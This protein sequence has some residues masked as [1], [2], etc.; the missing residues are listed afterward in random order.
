MVHDPDRIMLIQK[1]VPELTERFTQ[2]HKA[3]I[4]KL[5]DMV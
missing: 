5:T 3:Y 2:A 1:K 4:D